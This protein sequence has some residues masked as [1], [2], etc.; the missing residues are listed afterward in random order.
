MKCKES[1]IGNKRECLEYVKSVVPKILKGDLRIEGQKVSIP[2]KEELE[3]KV[4]YENDEEY[5]FGSLAIK[6]CWG[7]EP[8]LPEEESE[9]EDEEE[10]ELNEE[11]YEEIK[12]KDKVT[13]REPKCTCRPC[14]RYDHF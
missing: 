13:Y 5:N 8:E 3:Y 1:Y 11:V 2:G 4:K 9:E 6:I 14:R 10:D 7:E 12:K